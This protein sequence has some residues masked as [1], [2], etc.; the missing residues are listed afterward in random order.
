MNT[1][2]SASTVFSG[3]APD[4]V[5]I[6]DVSKRFV[7]RKDNS[8]KE[9]LVTFG[10]RGRRH[11]EEFWALRNVSTTIQAG[12]TVALIGHNGSGKSTLLKVIGGILDSTSGDVFRRGRIAALLELGAGFHPDL[13]GRENVFL[14]ASIMG[15]SRAETE[16][17]FDDILAFSGIG[18]FIDA[19]VKFYSSG[20]YVR[21]AFAVAVHTNP[22]LLLVDEVLAVGDEAFQKKCLD[23]IRSF[24]EEGRTI[25]LVTHSLGQVTE[26][27][28]RAILLNKGEVV[29]DGEPREAVAQFREILED[30]RVAENVVAAVPTAREAKIISAFVTIQNGATSSSVGQ[31]D[32]LIITA[33]IEHLVPSE[34]PWVYAIQ[35]E[36]S[37]GQPVYGTTSR[38]LGYSLK[39]GIGPREVALTLKDTHFG[40]GKYFVNVSILDFAGRHVEDLPQACSF[41]VASN[42]L[43]TG[44]TYSEPT[45]ADLGPSKY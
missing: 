2:N 31:G 16:A 4:V 28:D 45:F 34:A 21:L 27:C 19:Q 1:T 20:M 36:N 33:K 41:N 17:Q 44:V 43:A 18:S 42:P 10:R 38:R 32:D 23:K 30:R 12:H 22:D 29:F 7:L 26:L 9:R 15:L 3:P 11:R 14:N 5:V 25:V 40:T 13:S 39:P 37:L 8:L 24:Q 35:I 6:K